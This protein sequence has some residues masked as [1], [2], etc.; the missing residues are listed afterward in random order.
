MKLAWPVGL[1]LAAGV[2]CAG[3]QARA[4]SCPPDD[5]SLRP[6]KTTT[7]SGT[8]RYHNE[9]RQW[10]GLELASTV[11]SQR[12]FQLIF[13]KDSQ[14]HYRQT[15][16]LSGCKAT[17]TGE[18]EWSPT[19]YYSA[20]MY[21]ADGRIES[22]A[23]CHTVPVAPDPSKASI[24]PG[25]K[26][27]KSTITIDLSQPKKP[28]VG[29]A[30]RT[31]GRQGELQPWQAYADLFLTG[32]EVVWAGCRGDFQLMSA[33]VDGQPAKTDDLIAGKALLGPSEDHTSS[34]TITCVRSS[35]QV[36]SQ[37]SNK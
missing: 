1:V 11:C 8:I 28:M 3:L 6:G 16:S 17:V 10:I 32:G 25:V 23:S 4:Q 15:E 14:A 31:D 37:S 19:G 20:E 34:I 36:Q 2:F 24:L 33:S 30:W 29:K 22:D 7:V 12:E 9:L 18:I 35:N 27:Y 21:I 26:S 5:G 13:V